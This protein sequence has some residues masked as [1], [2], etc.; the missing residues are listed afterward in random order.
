MTSM[1]PSNI[2][3][4]EFYI[5]PPQAIEEQE[6]NAD[7]SDPSEM[8]EAINSLWG[9]FSSLMFGLSVLVFMG[10]PAMSIGIIIFLL[11][12]HVGKTAYETR[13][14]PTLCN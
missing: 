9:A 4:P 3:N 2:G 12:G 11:I 8:T 14:G 5:S 1:N 7:H 10:F 6:N 13:E